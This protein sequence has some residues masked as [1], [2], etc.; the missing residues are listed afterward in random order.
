MNVLITGARGYIGRYTTE[1]LLNNGHTV[2]DYHRGQNA[3]SN[4]NKNYI[5][6]HGECYDVPRMLHVF[7]EYKIDAIIHLAAQS[8]P[9]VSLEVPVETMEANLMTT[10]SILEAAR[11]TGIKRVVLYSSE[12]AY[13]DH[14]YDKMTLDKP[15]IPRTVYGVTKAATEMLGRVY[16]WQFDMS[17]VSIRCGRVYGGKQL[18][19]NIIK[20]MITAAAT[21]EKFVAETGGDAYA[22]LVHADDI[23]DITYRATIMDPSKVND[24][25][26]YNGFSHG[27]YLKDALATIKEFVP[28]FEYEMGPGLEVVNGIVNESQ[29][30]WDLSETERDLGFKPQYTLKEGLEAYYDFIKSELNL[31]ETNA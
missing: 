21:G 8:S 1:L 18:T 15:L 12:C 7:K 28:D 11:I 26:V 31:S 17:C 9:W 10:I 29:G 6:I 4:E 22:A 20:S 14:G 30:E 25:A 27:T 16:N 23:A 3:G 2:V 13:G 19:P 5:S 24:I